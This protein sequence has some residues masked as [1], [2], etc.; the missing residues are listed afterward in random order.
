[1]MAVVAPTLYDITTTQVALDAVWATVA[2]TDKKQLIRAN[3]NDVIVFKTVG[4][5]GGNV[6]MLKF[7]SGDGTNAGKAVLKGKY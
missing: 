2:E 5:N 7:I 6:R 1:M 4:T 3:A